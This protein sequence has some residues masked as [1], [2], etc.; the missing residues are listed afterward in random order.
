[1]GKEQRWQTEDSRRAKGL[2]WTE[3]ELTDRKKVAGE[4]KRAKGR[5]DRSGSPKPFVST[6]KAPQGSHGA[7]LL[8]NR[9]YWKLYVIF[10]PYLKLF[11]LY[12]L[13]QN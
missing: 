10:A 4:A 9:R 8:L 1:M 2:R 3:C 7:Q 11:P 6:T 12:C 13:V 5:L